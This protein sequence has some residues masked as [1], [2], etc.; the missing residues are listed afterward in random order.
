VTDYAHKEDWLNHAV[1]IRLVAKCRE[2]L[3]L[4]TAALHTAARDSTDPAVRAAETKVSSIEGF[5]SE[6]LSKKKVGANH[7]TEDR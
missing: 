1:T 6:M 4:A 2:D 5:L 7:G 3:R